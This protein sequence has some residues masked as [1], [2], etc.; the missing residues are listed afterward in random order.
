MNVSNSSPFI[1]F[2]I[3]FKGRKS[4]NFIANLP[5]I[6]NLYK[7]G[8]FYYS[9]IKDFTNKHIYGIFNPKIIGEIE[10]QRISNC[11]F[12]QL[13]EYVP[14]FKKLFGEQLQDV[15]GDVRENNI[16]SS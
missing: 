10:Y 12:Y 7:G 16:C 5:G 6:Y 8:Q 2:T 11:E 9:F 3:H 15:A 14:E 13:V 4:E 1:L